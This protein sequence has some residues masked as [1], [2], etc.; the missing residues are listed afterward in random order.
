MPTP[1]IVLLPGVGIGPEVMNSA[2]EALKAVGEFEFEEHSIGAG[3]AFAD[4]QALSEKTLTACQQADAVLLG[5]VSNP[6]ELL[7][8]RD[9][10]GLYA[11]LRPVKPFSELYPA[12]P[13]KRNVLEGNRK[14]DEGVNLLI[15]REL[16]GGIYYGRK[17]RTREQATDVC[18]YS[19]EQINRVA[20]RAFQ[21]AATKVTSVDKANVL[22]TSRL[23]REVVTELHEQNYAHLELNHVLV[24]NAAML[25]V[26]EPSRFD[27]ILT[28]N[29][30]GDILSDLAATIPG[31]IGLLPSASLGDQRPGLFEPVHGSAPDIAGRGRA[32]PIAMILS[33]AM[34]LDYGLGMNYEANRI[35]RAVWLAISK[36]LLTPDLGGSHDTASATKQ[37]LKYV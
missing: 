31:S 17:E 29:M 32:N 18:T 30:F 1:H 20:H 14:V 36:G 15:V 22:D 3:S 13:L 16:T 25:L 19:R 34:M 23:W 11:N 35:R 37:I 33:A 7:E 6:R 10:L 21:A 24:D 8:L 26:T 9:G 4:G 2:V 27:V 12:S 28:E 5:A